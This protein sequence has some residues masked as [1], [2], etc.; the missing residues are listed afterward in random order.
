[1]KARLE[2]MVS[3]A[4]TRCSPMKASEYPSRS[5]STT[6]SRTSRRTSAYARDGGWT[7]WMKNPSFMVGL[8]V[9]RFCRWGPTNKNPRRFRRRGL[10][11]E[12]SQALAGAVLPDY[13]DYVALIG[14]GS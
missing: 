7:G 13:D 6:A 8:L 2:V 12:L 5:A 14:A 3:A 4:S 11:Q 10:G 9:D 1:M